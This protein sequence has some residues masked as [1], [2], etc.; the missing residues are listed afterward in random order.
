MAK[1][2]LSP[3][4]VDVRS[5]VADMVFSKWKGVNYVRSRVIPSNPQSDGQ[6]AVRDALSQ[7]VAIWKIIS[8]KVQSNNNVYAEGTDKSGFNVFIGAN[9]KKRRDSQL[10]SITNDMGFT[11]LT[12][13]AAALS[14]TPYHK[15]DLTFAPTVPANTFMKVIAIPDDSTTD[16]MEFSFASGTTSPQTIDV[17]RANT[18]FGV[19]A[20]FYKDEDPVLGEDVGQNLGAFATSS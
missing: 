16:P 1:I 14:S 17:V 3:L 8:A 20:F 13:F 7:L 2:T 11:K 18:A 15:I 6:T 12:S 10:L 9:V 19:Y 5:K 4:I